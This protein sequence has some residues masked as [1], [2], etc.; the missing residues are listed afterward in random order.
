MAG[1]RLDFIKDSAI[2]KGGDFK[3]TLSFK[4]A[5]GTVKDLTG[6]TAYARVKYWTLEKEK[7]VAE[8]TTT[9]D[10]PNCIVTLL[11]PMANMLLMPTGGKEHAETTRYQWD[12][13]MKWADGSYEQI[14]YGYFEVMPRATEIETYGP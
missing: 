3:R 12:L 14:L 1:Q 6:C 4:N 10:G 9:V 2:P 8:M 11:I 7:A 13:Y 5:D